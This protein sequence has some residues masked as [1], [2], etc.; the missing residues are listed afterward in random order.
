MSDLSCN[1][2]I[3]C[4]TTDQMYC[5]YDADEQVL[6]TDDMPECEH[7][8]DNTIALYLCDLMCNYE[9]DNYGE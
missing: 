6:V 8:E 1:Q 2:C 3:H 5:I 4:V 9:E 7:F